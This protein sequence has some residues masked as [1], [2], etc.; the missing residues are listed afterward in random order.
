MP[1]ARDRFIIGSLCTYIIKI[2]F[3][4]YTQL[5][6]NNVGEYIPLPYLEVQHAGAG[7][8]DVA[9][10]GLLVQRVDLLHRIYT[11]PERIYTLLLL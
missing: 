7:R 4:I 5:K 8:V 10:G 11:L 3:T 2:L 1:S 9:D 6:S